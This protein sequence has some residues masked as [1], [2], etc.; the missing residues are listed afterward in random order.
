MST[1]GV[2]TFAK[3]VNSFVD[4]CLRQVVPDPLLHLLAPEWSWTLGEVCETPEVFHPKHDSQVG[5]GLAN[6]VVIHT[7]Q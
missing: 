7:L 5:R 3:V 2:Q 6:L 1:I 4:H